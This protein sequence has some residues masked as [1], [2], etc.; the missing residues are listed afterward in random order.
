MCYPQLNMHH[1]YSY[2]PHSAWDFLLPLFAFPVPASFALFP[3][4]FLLTPFPP[5]VF[6]AGT[7]PAVVVVVVVV[8]LPLLAA[9]FFAVFCFLLRGTSASLSSSSSS[10]STAIGASLLDPVALSFPLL[11][12]LIFGFCGDVDG[13]MTSP[14]ALLTGTTTSGTSLSRA[15][16]TRVAA[17]FAYAGSP[18]SPSPKFLSDAN[19]SHERRASSTGEA[20][21]VV[22]ESSPSPTGL[23]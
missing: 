11:D 18:A 5:V 14:D 12:L 2:R 21:L 20:G 23:S 8:D 7:L 19:V 22:G 6:L 16:K 15:E 13:V 10:S 4:A 1:H 3:V 9:L 17:C